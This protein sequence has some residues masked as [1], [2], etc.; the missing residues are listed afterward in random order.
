MLKG[1]VTVV[2]NPN[3]DFHSRPALRAKHAWFNPESAIVA[4]LRKE[5]IKHPR[6]VIRCKPTAFP[7][8]W[9]LHKSPDCLGLSVVLV[10]RLPAG[11]ASSLVACPFAAVRSHRG[12][13][14][15]SA[16]RYC[17]C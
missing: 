16:A 4:V 11:K 3:N 6:G 13:E 7:G 1:R 12:L 5:I 15:R 8:S 10:S 9:D 17:A 2:Q 14:L